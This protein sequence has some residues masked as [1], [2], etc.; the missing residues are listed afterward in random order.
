[1][2]IAVTKTKPRLFAGGAAALTYGSYLVIS[3]KSAF[4]IS[5]KTGF[6]VLTFC[7]VFSVYFFDSETLYLFF[8]RRLAS[9][10]CLATGTSPLALCCLECFVQTYKFKPY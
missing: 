9:N 2:A 1:M 6:Y 7:E 8:R 10:A 3:L 4:F 5:L